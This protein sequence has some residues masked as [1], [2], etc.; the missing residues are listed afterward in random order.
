VFVGVAALKHQQRR[1]MDNFGI[2]SKKL[3]KNQWLFVGVATLKH[4]QRQ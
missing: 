3:F 1:E 2:L 4:Q